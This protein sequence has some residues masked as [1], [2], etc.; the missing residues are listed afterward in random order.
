MPLVP[1]TITCL[2]LCVGMPN[3]KY[4]RCADPLSIILEE[5]QPWRSALIQREKFNIEYGP[6]WERIQFKS[7][8][9]QL[10]CE[11]LALL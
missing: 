1:G 2:P 3:A 9:N 4:V 5:V 7:N 6:F 8:L 11:E 10:A